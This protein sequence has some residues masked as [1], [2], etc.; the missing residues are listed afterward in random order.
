MLCDLYGK[1]S[2]DDKAKGRDLGQ[3]IV[4]TLNEHPRLKA[5]NAELRAEVERYREMLDSVPGVD[6]QEGKTTTRLWHFLTG[7][8]KGKWWTWVDGP[9]VLY[10]TFSDAYAAL[11]QP[12]PASTDAGDRVQEG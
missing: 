9:D 11:K 12:R 5:E 2:G 8:N 1:L 4:T 6:I 7:K 10:D 3:Q